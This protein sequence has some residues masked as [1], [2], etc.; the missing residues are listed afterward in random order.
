MSYSAPTPT[1][2]WGHQADHTVK[3]APGAIGNRVIENAIVR[4]VRA[5]NSK[6]ASLGKGLTI[7]STCG[8]SNRDEFT[9]TIKAVNNKNNATGPPNSDPNEGCGSSYACI[10]P[11]SGGT[12]SSGP[13][14]HMGIMYMVFEDPPWAAAEEEDVL[15][16]KTGKWERTEYLWTTNKSLN[17]S[18]VSYIASREVFYVYVDR[19][20][21]H[22]F[23]HTL[24]LPDFY[25]D[26]TGLKGLDAVMNTSFEIQDEDIA[27]LEAIYLLHSPH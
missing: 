8:I 13:G 20:M 14:A 21:L 11:R 1:H 19:V 18:R 17:G 23:G 5:W 9:V 3:Y 4:A 6:M 10:K 16:N 27:Q 2:W 26:T 22:E 12:S 24:G 7:C 25:S 15:G